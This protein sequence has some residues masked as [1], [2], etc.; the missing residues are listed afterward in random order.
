MGYSE[1][2][3]TLCGVSFNIGRIRKVGEP[4]SAAWSRWGAGGAGESALHPNP[5]FYHILH[6]RNGAVVG[7]QPNE[8]LPRP[9]Y[10]DPSWEGY[11]SCGRMGTS[12]PPDSG[13]SFIY[14]GPIGAETSGFVGEQER[15]KWAA[16]SGGRDR[17]DEEDEDEDFVPDPADEQDYEM[18]EYT[19][20]DDDAAPEPEGTSTDVEMEDTS[21]DLDDEDS[22]NREFWV[23]ALVRDP[24]MRET[25]VKGSYDYQTAWNWGVP[26]YFS[27]LPWEQAKD[28]ILPNSLVHEHNQQCVLDME[29][30]AQDEPES[31]TGAGVQERKRSARPEQRREHIAGPGCQMLGGYSGC[32]IS[33]AEMRHCS[34]SQCLVRKP[35]GWS[36]DAFK[37]L[38][39]DEEFER[40]GDFFLSGL[41]GDMP[42]R[43]LS[44]PKV[45]PH[46]HGCGMP[47]AENWFWNETD[48]N[49]YALPFHPSC[50]EVYKR[51]A[52]RAK[53]HIE[54]SGLT[55]WWAERAKNW[56]EMED[57]PR[58]PSVRECRDQEW[59][60]AP[61]TAWLAANPLYVPKLSE[62]FQASVSAGPDF[63]ISDGAF[64]VPERQCEDRNNDLFASLPNELRISILDNLNVKDIAAL[65]LSSRAF[66]QIPIQ[67]FQKMLNRHMPWLWEA[68]PTHSSLIQR[69]YA[70]WATCTPA[71]ALARLDKGS[72][73]VAVLDDYCR[74]VTL[75]MPELEEVLREAISVEREKALEEARLEMEDHE[76]RRPFWLPPL[77]TNY[78]VLYTLITRHWGELKGLRNRAR[79][80]EDC[81]SIL[82]DID[83]MRAQ[84]VIG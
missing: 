65:R 63:R 21:H 39:D 16:E 12:C 78:Y 51:A 8:F 59:L 57:I 4:R 84:G 81:T 44:H 56:R 42:S 40:E 62:I 49:D 43:D 1:V 66:R 29:D 6:Y 17:E 25:L 79:I 38:D 10:M 46:R 3:C 68:W 60:H 2:L 58:H 52:L 23:R 64:S 9:D 11:G 50:F 67:Y 32:E 48:I 36:P 71:E 61:G 74:I 30:C 33:V 24:Q 35:K 75:E 14:R 70:F 37:V 55:N 45:H 72:R 19:S 69:P 41:C 31:T 20:D 7:I 73:D 47:H 54:V 15:R 34:V 80:W 77:K 53:G 26:A 18:L 82:G 76:D 13:C 27:S 22:A 83:S 28:G 5:G